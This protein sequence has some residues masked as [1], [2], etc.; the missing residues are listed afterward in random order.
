MKILVKVIRNIAIA[1]LVI[2]L[3]LSAF[4]HFVHYPNVIAAVRLGLAPA[5]KTPTLLPWHTVDPSTHPLVWPT[6]KEEMPRTV[7]YKGVSM[8]WDEFLQKSYTN[9]FLV[10]RNGTIT[11]EYYNSKAGM[12]S[13]TL[14]PSYSM[15]KTLT[16]LVIGQLVN[17]GKIRES[18]TFVS[19]FPQWKTGT[20]FDQVTVQSLLDMEAGVGVKDDYPNGP[21][22]WG[23]GIAQ[24][25]ATT[26]MNWFMTHNRKMLEAPDT[27]PDYR[28]VDTQ[29]LGLIIQKVTG[30]TVS[31][32]FSEN[33][34]KPIGA[35]TAATWNV[36][37]I[38]G[39][40]KTFCCFNASARDFALIGQLMINK[41]STHTQQIISPAW[42][43]RISTPVVK[44]DY[45]WGYGA[46][47]W[48][49]Y[50]GIDLAMGLHGQ[51]IYA[52]PG[53]KTVIVKLSDYPNGDDPQDA[54]S[55]VLRQVDLQK[56]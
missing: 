55:A 27:K 53:S 30:Q 44:L 49:P 52:D 24:M 36:D 10:V 11:Y 38:N 56:H 50:P 23:V 25:Y 29:M 1:L 33:I 45:G 28:S 39:H 54:I 9:A 34:W 8:S 13:T 26:D 31:H 42:M 40:E 41:G 46:Q 47:V 21:A 2:F 12:T 48:H 17:Q 15:A 16:S 51:Q 4:F 37:H 32:Y 6:G 20:S 19:F 22:G 5:S 7:T 43:K 35:T 14:L 3:G 18:D